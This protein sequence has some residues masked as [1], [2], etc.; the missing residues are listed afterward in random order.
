MQETRIVV[1][2]LKVI[3]RSSFQRSS[4]TQLGALSEAACFRVAVGN[5]ANEDGGKTSRSFFFN[6][7]L[8]GHPL[9]Q[10]LIRYCSSVQGYTESIRAQLP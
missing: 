3:S 6:H 5:G 9:K 2:M 10:P 7:T 8:K 4:N 1:K